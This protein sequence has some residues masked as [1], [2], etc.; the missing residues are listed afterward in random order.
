MATTRGRLV[1]INQ[2]VLD[3]EDSYGV[4]YEILVSSNV[5]EWETIYS[6]TNGDGGIDDLSVSGSGRYVRMYGTSR[7]IIQGASYGYSL[8]EF[9]VYGV[10]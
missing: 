5:S 6:T 3:W 2:V 1:Q 4:A 8:Y 9:E 7:V 10:P